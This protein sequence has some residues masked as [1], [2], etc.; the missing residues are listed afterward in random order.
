MLLYLVVELA[1]TAG[2]AAG[3]GGM[4]AYDHYKI[5]KRIAVLLIVLNL[6][7]NK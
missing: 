4:Y 6:A 2:A 3:A 7:V 5:E 1:A